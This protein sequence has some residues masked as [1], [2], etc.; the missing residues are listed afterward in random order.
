LFAMLD[1]GPNNER[2]M[3][4]GCAFYRRLLAQSD[5]ALSDANLPRTEVEEG[6]KQLEARRKPSG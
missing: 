2:L 5:T 3:E 6:L 1:A 4:F